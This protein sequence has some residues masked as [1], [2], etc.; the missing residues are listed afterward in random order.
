MQNHSVAEGGSLPADVA[1]ALQTP[2]HVA[3]WSSTAPK[4]LEVQKGCCATSREKAPASLCSAV[5][6]FRLHRDLPG[7]F[8]NPSFPGAARTH[9]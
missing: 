8:P 4:T 3:L 1:S 7:D 9:V 6:G 5:E 2:A